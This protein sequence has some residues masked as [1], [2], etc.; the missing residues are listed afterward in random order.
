LGG[1]A[2]ALRGADFTALKEVNEYIRGEER[3]AERSIEKERDIGIDRERGH[4]FE[5]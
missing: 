4:G 2:E 3:D 1:L 5:R